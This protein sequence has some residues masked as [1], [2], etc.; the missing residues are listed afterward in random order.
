M[1]PD[2]N[3]FDIRYRGIVE[4]Q[5]RAE[6]GISATKPIYDVVGS[7]TCGNIPLEA[8]LNSW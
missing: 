7:N 6:L 5:G 1:V 4:L 2:H 8:R 3:G